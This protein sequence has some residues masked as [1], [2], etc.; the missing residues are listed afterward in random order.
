[1]KADAAV[2]RRTALMMFWNADFQAEE[3]LIAAAGMLDA[4]KQPSPG[5]YM[6]DDVSNAI[7]DMKAEAFKA[8]LRAGLI[9]DAKTELVR[10]GKVLDLKDTEDDKGC[11]RVYVIEYHNREFT[12]NM[13]NGEVIKI[14]F[15]GVWL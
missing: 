5:Y 12:V 11:H 1:M 3:Q 7:T 6:A 14:N 2:S 8:K 10:Y 4:L 9:Q 15:P 13:T